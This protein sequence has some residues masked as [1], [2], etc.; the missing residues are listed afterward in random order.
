MLLYR[1]YRQTTFS[2]YLYYRTVQTI[3]SFTTIWQTVPSNLRRRTAINS[4]FPRVFTGFPQD[5]YY[6][7]I[8]IYTIVVR[9]Y[10]FKLL[11]IL[12]Y[13]TFRINPSNCPLQYP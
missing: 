4:G 2:I 9:S 10:D 3:N 6:V 5:E 1:L 12:Y 8:Y 13:Y 7:L 11:S